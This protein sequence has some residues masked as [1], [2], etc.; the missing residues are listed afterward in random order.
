MGQ[1]QL[2]SRSVLTLDADDGCWCRG[3]VA[4]LSRYELAPEPLPGCS[5]WGW[6]MELSKHMFAQVYH[7]SC[8]S[9]SQFLKGSNSVTNVRP[10]CGCTG[11]ESLQYQAPWLGLLGWAG[12]SESAEAWLP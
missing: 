6:D 9:K 10:W 3:A 12:P 2:V 8:H 5:M 4:P 11:L 7:P 1:I